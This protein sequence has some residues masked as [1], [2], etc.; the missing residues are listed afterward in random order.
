ML[1][2]ATSIYLPEDEFTLPP[3]L[4]RI[5]NQ[6]GNRDTGINVE[7][8]DKNK[9]R[10]LSGEWLRYGDRFDLAANFSI[11]VI[12]RENIQWVG[13]G[14]LQGSFGTSR[15]AKDDQIY[16]LNLS[17]GWARIWIKPDKNP[18]K[19][20]IH[21]AQGVF[22]TSNAEFWIAT[23]PESTEIYLIKGEVKR[24]ENNLPLI[25]RTY[26]RFEGSNPRPTYL[27]KAWDKDIVEVR[28]ASSY[29]N[30]VKLVSL[31]EPEWKTGRIPHLYSQYRK[32]GWQK[33]DP[34]EK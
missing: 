7:A 21:T 27:A 14:V 11:Q 13:G 25:N 28:I 15:Y 33:A 17:R 16:D 12:Q 29:P 19:L 26:A 22:E 32:K 6:I 23:R 30:L 3:L 10:A 8:L 20:Q 1:S 5:E 4:Y 18:V 9:R 34:S 31:T 24:I 2:Q